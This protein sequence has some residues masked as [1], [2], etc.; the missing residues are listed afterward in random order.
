MD[1]RLVMRWQFIGFTGGGHGE[2][3]DEEDED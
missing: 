2:E 1:Q 3:G